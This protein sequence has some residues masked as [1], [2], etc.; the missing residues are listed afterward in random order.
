[1]SLHSGT[2][3]LQ[4]G[5]SVATEFSDLSTVM[6]PQARRAAQSANGDRARA[7][8][9]E[10]VF[11]SWAAPNDASAPESECSRACGAPFWCWAGR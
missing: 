7:L 10:G 9:G 2:H 4:Y 11:W 3:K 8:P 6:Q 1:M 5:V